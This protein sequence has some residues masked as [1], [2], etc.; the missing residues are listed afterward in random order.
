MTV[1]DLRWR[2]SK[3]EEVCRTCDLAILRGVSALIPHELRNWSRIRSHVTALLCCGEPGK[4][5]CSPE[6]AVY[7]MR[8][9]TIQL[10]IFSWR[11][12]GPAERQLR[13]AGRKPSLQT[14]TS[15]ELTMGLFGGASSASSTHPTPPASPK[16]MTWKERGKAWGHVAVVKGTAVSDWAGGHLNNIADKVCMASMCF[17]D[18]RLTPWTNR[19][20]RSVRA[21][22]DV[23]ERS[24]ATDD[25][26]P[27]CRLLPGHW[28]LPSRDGQSY[29]DPQ[30]LHRCVP[31]PVLLFDCALSLPLADHLP[32]PLTWHNSGRS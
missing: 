22:A 20:G 7:P 21:C 30:S 3:A 17:K 14:T 28:R 5:D 11:C 15:L 29:E 31:T 26:W 2:T 24:S 32:F 8:S 6:K 13:P 23:C 16:P 10:T 18:A 9:V 4:R 19:R 1:E 25:A 12:L 27:S